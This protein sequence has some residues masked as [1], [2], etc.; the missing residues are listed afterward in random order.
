MAAL[1][2]KM[3]GGF[4]ACSSSGQAVVVSGKKNQALLTYL[5]MNA[6][7]RLSREKLINL[8][9]SDRGDSQARSS[10]RQT[11]FALRQDLAGIDPTPL[12]FDGD[13]VAVN[14]SAISTDVANFAAA[15]AFW[16]GR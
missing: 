6:G 11:L 16:L 13:I 12:V 2:L 10:L 8:L 9:W 4:A 3:L 7:K 14:E 15:C 5:A 1:R